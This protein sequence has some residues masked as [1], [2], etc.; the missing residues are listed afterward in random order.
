MRTLSN[1]AVTRRRPGHRP[2]H[3]PFIMSAILESVNE[4]AADG[5]ALAEL[6]AA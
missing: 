5:T 2:V 6:I 3:H 1:Q 4:T